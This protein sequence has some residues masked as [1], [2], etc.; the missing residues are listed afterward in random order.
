MFVS[1]FWQY[2]SKDIIVDVWVVRLF[3]IFYVLSPDPLYVRAG[4]AVPQWA[5]PNPAS[6]HS[7][8]VFLLPSS[9]FL[10]EAQILALE[11]YGHT[12]GEIKVFVSVLYILKFLEYFICF[13]T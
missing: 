6:L 3:I 5:V 1:L 9:Q 8:G 10:S 7:A 11:I 13:F 12:A 2:I 4:P